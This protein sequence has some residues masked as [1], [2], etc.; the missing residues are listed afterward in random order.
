MA[1]QIE[2]TVDAALQRAVDYEVHP[3][4]PGHQIASHGACATVREQPEHARFGDLLAQRLVSIWLIGE[5]A[6]I[7]PLP[8]VTGSRMGEVV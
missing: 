4:K 2:A 7:K 8:L 1:V 3:M 6:D 5:E